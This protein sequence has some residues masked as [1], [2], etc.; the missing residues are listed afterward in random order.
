MKTREI[1]STDTIEAISS[2]VIYEYLVYGH[3]LTEIED[4]I[5]DNKSDYK[6]WFAKT[7][8]NYHG[9]ATSL[10]SKNKGLYK[11]ETHLSLIQRLLLDNGI[12]KP[13]KKILIRK[14]KELI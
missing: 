13:L 10:N 5:F 6:G 2:K 9:I 12:E 1:Q 11:G 7:I 3:S 4:S 8:L 14:I